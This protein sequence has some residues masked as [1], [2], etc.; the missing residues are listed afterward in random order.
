MNT[1]PFADGETRSAPGPRPVGTRSSRNP[2]LDGLRAIAVSAVVYRHLGLPGLYG[3]GAGVF[4]FFTLS[5]FIITFLLCAELARTGQV[6]M[7]A[8]W[9]RRARRL[10]PALLVT[11]GLS[12]G[13]ATGLGKEP[14]GTPLSQALPA[15]GYFSNWWRVWASYHPTTMPL[16]PFDHTW[17]LSIEEQFYL[18]WPLLFLLVVAGV[19]RA[20]PLVAVLLVLV[21][22]EVS[23][24]TRLLSWNSA[25]PVLSANVLYNRTDCI[26]ELLLIGAA[27]GMLAWHLLQ[28]PEV[29]RRLPLWLLPAAGWAGGLVLAL[30]FLLQ[31]APDQPHRMHV[32]WTAG[33]TGIALGVSALC[34]HVML[35]PHATLARVLSVPPLP[36]LGIISYGIYLYHYPVLLFVGPLF[37]S[38]TGWGDAAV[39]ACTLALAVMSWWL[40]ERPIMLRRRAPRRSTPEEFEGPVVANTQLEAAPQSS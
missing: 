36:Q 12:V 8:F 20:R 21:L 31:P 10:M 17:S 37:G 38:R 23:A 18:T 25:E 39:V 4:A 2:A 6:R 24:A 16:G 13:L 27:T 15:L 14:V 33:L 35:N 5:G 1:I 28:H 9:L 26:G 22:A 34:L 19:L 32:F 11:V 3:G 30:A 40:I 7:G 29:R